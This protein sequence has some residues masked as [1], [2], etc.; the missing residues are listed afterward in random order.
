MLSTVMVVLFDRNY[1]NEDQGSFDWIESSVK[2]CAIMD[3][4]SFP[5]LLGFSVKEFEFCF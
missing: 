2:S 1:S 4:R 5:K 3:R